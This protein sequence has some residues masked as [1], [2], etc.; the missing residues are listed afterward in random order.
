MSEREDLHERA[1]AIEEALA[2]TV[3]EIDRIRAAPFED[4]ASFE[5]RAR[6]KTEQHQRK[7][8]AL[9]REIADAEK[10]FAALGTELEDAR[11]AL[12]RQEL[13]ASAK[14]EHPEGRT[15]GYVLFGL[16]LLYLLY[17]CVH[18]FLR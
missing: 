3:A 13:A 1:V 11:M 2:E 18:M 8:Y 9:E 12:D 5:K 4:P 15:V 7:V 6:K 17:T 10:E 14:T 16:G